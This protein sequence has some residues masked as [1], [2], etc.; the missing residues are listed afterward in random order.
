M[1]PCN[2]RSW[3]KAMDALAAQVCT[4]LGVSKVKILQI[5]AGVTIVLLILLGL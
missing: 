5:V 4:N 1:T 3:G 2:I